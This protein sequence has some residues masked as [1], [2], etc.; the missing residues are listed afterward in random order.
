MRGSQQGLGLPSPQPA[1]VPALRLIAGPVPVPEHSYK[2]RAHSPDEG[3]WLFVS[4]RERVTFH[5]LLP[6]PDPSD[7]K[8]RR[9]TDQCVVPVPML[10]RQ[11]LSDLGGQEGWR[12][13]C[14]PLANPG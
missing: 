14:S 12:E 2:D 10:F 6:A 13:S 1:L 7:R 3:A 4:Y 9:R 11:A 8:Q 5:S